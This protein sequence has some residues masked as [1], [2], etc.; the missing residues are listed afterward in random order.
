MQENPAHQSLFFT[1]YFLLFNLT[2]EP[3]SNLKWVFS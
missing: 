2:K 1:F 3:I